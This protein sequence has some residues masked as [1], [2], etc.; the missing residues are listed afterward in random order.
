[1][2]EQFSKI[3]GY[4]IKNALINLQQLILEV[5]DIC[6]LRCK[7]CGYGDLYQ[8]HNPRGTGTM[9][10]NKACTILDY[11]A[12]LWKV[13]IN[14][15]IVKPFFLSFYGGEP[16]IGIKL[17]KDIIQYYESLNIKCK[18]V[19]Y[20]MTTNGLLIHSCM[21]YLVE[22]EFH[23]LISLDGNEGDHSYRIDHHGR[24]SHK[25][26]V[27]NIM[28]LQQKYPEYFKR[29]VRF[30]TVLHNKNSVESASQ[31]IKDTFGKETTFSQLNN[32]G[33]R[34]D[35]RNEF[36]KI[37]QNINNSIEKCGN[38]DKL[39]ADLFLEAPS[40]SQ[41]THFIYKY[42]GNMFDNY[43]SLIYDPK[44]IKITPTGT[45]IPFQKKIYITVNGKILQC[46]KINHEFVLGQVFDDKVEM[47]FD[48]IAEFA[49]EIIF[50]LIKQCITC[51][52][53]KRCS[54]CVFQIDEIND[55]N[56]TCRNY[57]SVKSF[58]DYKNYNLAYLD[59][60][61]GL[62]KKIMNDVSIRS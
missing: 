27:E 15:S 36:F 26:V 35:K 46:E 9:T 55:S 57:T 54:Q 6:N 19:Y 60:H 2:N 17:I 4:D 42:S 33:I 13:N 62:Y 25:I 14:A 40:T 49:N 30:N 7:Y 48:H 34:K 44:N 11:L 47:D 43:S 41:L 10:L 39:E 20:S 61:P 51:A 3:K 59:K 45:C 5:T 8:G 1:M 18:R 28:L 58:Q 53:R 21:D 12:K 38:R 37:Y 31:Y 50:R 32:S 22:K 52:H 56:P 16:L 23:L 29:N 24:N